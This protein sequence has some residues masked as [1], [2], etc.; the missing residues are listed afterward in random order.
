VLLALGYL[1]VR[2]IRIRWQGFQRKEDPPPDGPRAVPTSIFSPRRRRT[3]SRNQQELPSDTVR[4]WYA[5]ALLVLQRLGLPK[6]PSRTPGEYLREVTV[7]FPECAP[8]FAALTR[9]YEDVR[10]GSLRFD[11]DTLGR[12][13]GNRQLAMS[14]LG[15]AHRLEPEPEG[16]GEGP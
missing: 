5:E 12:L 3:R 2:T 1:L 8:G 7:A 11:R 10:Y 16:K 4:R 13:E 9:A 14:V 6:A 15:R